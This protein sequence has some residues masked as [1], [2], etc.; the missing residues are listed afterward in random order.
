MSKSFARMGLQS[1]L[2]AKK[3]LQYT[4]I[5]E[6]FFSFHLIKLHGVILK[7]TIPYMLIYIHTS[8]V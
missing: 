1:A 7:M 2:K 4:T 5:T 8:S 3:Y 6:G